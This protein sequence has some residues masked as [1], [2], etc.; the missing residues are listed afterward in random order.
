MTFTISKL[1]LQLDAVTFCGGLFCK[2]LPSPLGWEERSPEEQQGNS[3][4]LT[5]LQHGVLPST[6]RK[7]LSN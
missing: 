5:T 7:I 1:P 2:Q 6:D 4:P 3:C